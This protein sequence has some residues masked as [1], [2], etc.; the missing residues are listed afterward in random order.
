MLIGLFIV[1]PV[2]LHPT[3]SRAAIEGYGSI[4]SGDGVVF[5]GETQVMSDPEGNAEE[6]ADSAPLLPHEQEPGSY[7]VPFPPSAV[8]LNHSVSLRH[9]RSVGEK[10]GLPDIHGKR[11]WATPDFYLVFVITGICRWLLL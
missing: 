7:Q 2:P 8:E 11:L 3:S 5:V 1:K 10:D 6:E 9:E 4:P